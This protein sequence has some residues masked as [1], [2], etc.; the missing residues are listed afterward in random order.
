[1][2]G[3]A[4]DIFNLLILIFSQGTGNGDASVQAL[5]SIEHKTNP[6]NKMNPH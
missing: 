5:I 2:H 1:M 6:K 3:M 4:F